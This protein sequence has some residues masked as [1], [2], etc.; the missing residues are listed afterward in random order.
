MAVFPLYGASSGGVQG[1]LDVTHRRF[2][3]VA[4]EL[5]P[6][7]LA[8][9]PEDPL[10]QDLVAAQ[11]TELSRVDVRADALL[12]ELDPATTF[13]LIDDWET[14]LGLPE[15]STPET[16]EARRAAVLAKLLAQAGH[17]QSKPW[18]T[19][20]LA[21]LG[22]PP[23][24][25]LQGQEVMTCIDDCVDEL[26]DEEWM[27]VWQ[28]VVQH[29]VDDALLV[30]FVN[31]NALLG[32]LPVVHFMWTEFQLGENPLY[33]VACTNAGFVAAGGF[34]GIALYAGA[35]HYNPTAWSGAPPQPATLY[36]MAAIGE[37]L[38]ACGADPANF[39]RSVDGGATWSHV[40]EATVSMFCITAGTAPGTAIAAGENCITWRTVNSGVSWSL[41]TIVDADLVDIHGLTRCTGAVIAVAADG[42]I[43]RTTNNG[44]SWAAV[45]DAGAELRGVGAWE[46]VVIAVGAGGVIV[47]SVDGGLT[48]APVASPTSA[49]LRGVVGTPAGRWTAC[50]LGGV[51]LWSLDDGVTWTLQPSPTTEDLF[52]VT[53]HV[54]TDRALIVGDNITIIV[55]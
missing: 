38:V 16:L 14:E 24:Y 48:W 7:G 30:C 50:G 52:A 20:F 44:T 2:E 27:Y 34:A 29:G 40:A 25:F 31:K 26:T 47:R 13:G 11:C 15:C 45:G 41:A 46:L 3:P 55:E 37:V 18:W 19:D 36:A 10:R 42:R 22:Y 54:P 5:L 53:R 4:H 39:L 33:C 28:L 32:S 51:I 9:D 49:T 17:D 35:D 21:K 43:F 12:R 23:E 1:L 8:W 6:R